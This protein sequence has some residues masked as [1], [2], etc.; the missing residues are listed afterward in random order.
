MRRVFLALLLPLIPAPVAR[1]AATAPINRIEED[2]ELV[3]ATTDVPAAGPQITTAMSPGPVQVHP[4]INFNLNYREGSS[5]R[6]GGLQIEVFENSNLTTSAEKGSAT[7]NTD[8]ETIT[9]TQRLALYDGWLNYRIKQG[10]SQTWGDFGGWDL[11]VWFPSA[12][13][14]LGDYSPQFSKSKSGVGWQA[15]HVSSMKLLRVRYYSDDTLVRTD[16]TPL[17]IVPASNAATTQ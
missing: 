6:A 5:F 13:G 3:I 10:H 9:W 11:S 8:G 14:D 15:D 12:L 1:E 4:D 16:D 7:L 2:W 17:T